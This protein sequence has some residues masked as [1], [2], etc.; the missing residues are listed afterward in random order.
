MAQLK[1]LCLVVSESVKS[2]AAYT[3]SQGQTCWRQLTR[4]HMD[5]AR[6]VLVLISFCTGLTVD[7]TTLPAWQ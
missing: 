4:T 6:F 2:K 5:E 3:A 1:S 7:G